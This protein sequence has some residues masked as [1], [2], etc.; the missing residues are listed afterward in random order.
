[1][2]TR[3]HNSPAATA[4]IGDISYTFVRD[5]LVQWFDVPVRL[6]FELD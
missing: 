4:G 6:F 3:V 2:R 5:S 1:M